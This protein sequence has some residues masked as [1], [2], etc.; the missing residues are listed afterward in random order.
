MSILGPLFV[1]ALFGMGIH[2]A[3]KQKEENDRKMAE[4]DAECE[5]R[6]KAFEAECEARQKALE[7]RIA[8][9]K[10][11]AERRA[12][13]TRKRRSIPCLF[14]KELSEDRF[15]QIVYQSAK[16]IKRIKMVYIDGPY[17]RCIVQSQ[18]GISDWEFN[19]DF[20]DYG[21]ITGTCWR[22]QENQDSKI[23]LRLVQIIQNAIS[24]K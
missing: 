7:E 11:E 20:N 3:K 6:R 15:K 10:A 19:L 4:L 14:T 5:A 17:V 23:P 8:R 22:R 9:E 13:E 2:S 18:S 16:Q 12:E 21:R 1:G 24:A